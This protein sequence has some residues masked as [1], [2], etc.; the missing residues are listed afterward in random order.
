M[1]IIYSLFGAFFQASEMAIKKK[2]L[3]T[4]GVN[5]FIAFIAFTFAG[6][7]LWGVYFWQGGSLWPIYELSDKFWQGMF[8]GVTLNIL[9]VYFL[10]KALD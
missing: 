4:R 1:W 9:A 10:Y 2:A 7:L 8:W 6:L 3:Q 5:N